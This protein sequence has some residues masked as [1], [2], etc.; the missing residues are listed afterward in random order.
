MAFNTDTKI[1][2]SHYFKWTKSELNTPYLPHIFHIQIAILRAQLQKVSFS[3]WYLSVIS[4]GSAWDGHIK[5]ESFP[6]HANQSWK[7]ERDRRTK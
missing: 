1:L 2:L 6:G 3:S 4:I 7:E 5:K